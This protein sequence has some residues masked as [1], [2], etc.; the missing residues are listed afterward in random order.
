MTILKLATAQ[1]LLHH[2]SH[3]PVARISLF[4]RR[5]SIPEYLL[6]YAR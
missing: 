5:P 4:E 6:E 1:H 3:R 2:F